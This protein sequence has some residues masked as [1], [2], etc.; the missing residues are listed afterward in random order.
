MSFFSS[1]FNGH[2][3]KILDPGFY[4]ETI[5]IIIDWA[6]VFLIGCFTVL[7][8]ILASWIPAYRAGK[9]KPMDLLRKN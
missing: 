5:P 6:A 3:V 7:C 2:E 4:L 9:L 1:L 8:S